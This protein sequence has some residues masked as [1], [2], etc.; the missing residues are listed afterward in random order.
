MP[1]AFVVINPAAGQRRGPEVQQRVEQALA[2]VGLSAA[3]YTT[4]APGDATD[5]VREACEEGFDPIV[6]AAGDGTVHEAVAGMMVA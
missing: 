6:V 2:K 3:I 5:A 1:E 4:K